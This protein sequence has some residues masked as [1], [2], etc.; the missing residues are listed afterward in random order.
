MALL[1]LHSAYPLSDTCIGTSVRSS[2]DRSLTKAN[3]TDAYI[4]S[5]LLFDFAR[6]DKGIC[7]L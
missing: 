5:K 6:L 1:L 2:D 4:V 3:T 7:P